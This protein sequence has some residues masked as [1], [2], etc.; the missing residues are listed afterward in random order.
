MPDITVTA[1]CWL[2][3]T[4]Q[5]EQGTSPWSVG[6]SHCS[7]HSTRKAPHI[8]LPFIPQL[9][10]GSATPLS[11]YQALEYC[12]QTLFGTHLGLAVH[13]AGQLMRRVQ[14]PDEREGGEDVGDEH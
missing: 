8:K 4:P 1:T 6:A 11:M 7:A 12:Y 2:K 13:A 14:Q 5:T 9:L 3:H 10:H